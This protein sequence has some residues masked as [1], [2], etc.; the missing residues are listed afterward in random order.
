MKQES[1]DY[2][3]RVACIANANIAYHQMK[4]ALERNDDEAGE[5]LLMSACLEMYGHWQKAK[6]CADPP[7][8]R[9]YLAAQTSVQMRDQMQMLDRN[10]WPEEVEGLSQM[11]TAFMYLFK[12]M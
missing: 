2:L 7:S 11:M 4:S 9:V 8:Q 5:A 3:D 1:V 12:H 10:E 6:P